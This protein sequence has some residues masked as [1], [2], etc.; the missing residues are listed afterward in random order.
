[1]CLDKV[2]KLKRVVGQ[3]PVNVSL[4][5]EAMSL[6]ETWSGWSS[7]H[8]GVC[9]KVVGMYCTRCGRCSPHDS[10]TGSLDH[11]MDCQVTNLK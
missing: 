5:D 4:F 11:E 2:I 8:G 1:V 9:H 6:H 3:E 7:P 10:M